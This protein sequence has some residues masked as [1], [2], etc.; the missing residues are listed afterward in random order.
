MDGIRSTHLAVA[1][2]NTALREAGGFAGE[3]GGNASD[4]A[5]ITGTAE[6]YLQTHAY[7]NIVTE[8]IVE[9]KS[10]APRRKFV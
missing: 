1:E 8:E 7:R 3:Y 2:T 9:L 4:W 6:E 10:E 5:R